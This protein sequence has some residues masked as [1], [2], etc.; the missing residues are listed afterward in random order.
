M[1]MLPSQDLR[2]A[3]LPSGSLKLLQCLWLALALLLSASTHADGQSR[4]N[5]P[6]I[7]NSNLQRQPAEDAGGNEA[8][9]YRFDLFQMLLEQ[10]GL[11]PVTS[12]N[13][14][15]NSPESTAIVILG[16]LNARSISPELQSFLSGGALLI[17]SDSF[18]KIPWLFEVQQGPVIANRAETRYQDFAD[19]I[20]VR[21]VS[22]RSPLLNGIDR[23][24]VNRTGWISQLTPALGTWEVLASLPNSLSPQSSSN[25]PVL[26]AY[27]SDQSNNGIF[28][29][30]GDQSVFS[31]GM[32]WHGDNAMLAINVCRSLASG[33]RTKL[34]FVLDGRVQASYLKGPIAQEL[35]SELP[36]K[37]P[38]KLPN[39][40]P[41]K[42]PENLPPIPPLPPQAV[43]KLELAEML[44]VANGVVSK[45][46]DS[47]LPNELVSNQPRRM[48]QFRYQ[49]ILWILLGV[50]VLFFGIYRL[51]SPT[52]VASVP[53]SPQP[54]MMAGSLARSMP[55]SPQKMG[56]MARLLARDSLRQATGSMQPE[57]WRQF[58]TRHLP[59]AIVSD[60]TAIESLLATAESESS[61][62]FSRPA[63]QQLLKTME[64]VQ[65]STA[66]SVSPLVVSS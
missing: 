24:V 59:P 48:P 17:A 30:G 45:V 18:V 35:P 25:R 61:I 19:C 11:Q 55:P 32:L 2:A 28:I 52:R 16:R 63:F 58:V 29:L 23:L 37:L 41:D 34:L 47:D 8:W 9:H 3:L 46:E 51:L 66:N 60:Q 49:R 54:S 10:S 31:N 39:Q 15:F 20:E 53:V 42:L 22:T 26:A 38:D 33:G 4:L 65:L 40:L 43:P 21:D 44:R 36:G 27:H 50:I 62:E 64:Q 57:I 7:A 5:V 14:A 13:D 6:G 12:I 56:E 1:L